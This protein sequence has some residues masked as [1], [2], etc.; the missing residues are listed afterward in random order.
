MGTI[1]LATTLKE[2]GLGLNWFTSISVEIL[3]ISSQPG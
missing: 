1:L 3:T 2:L